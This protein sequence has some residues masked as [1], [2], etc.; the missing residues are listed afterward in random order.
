FSNGT[1]SP[2]LWHGT[3]ASWEALPFPEDF[4]DDN[5]G[6]AY[7]AE[8]ACWTV[9]TGGNYLYAGGFVTRWR[10]DADATNPCAVIWLS[11]LSACA[12]DFNHNGLVDFFDY[13]D[14]VQA[15]ANNDPAADFNHDGQIDFFDYLD[16]GQA[17]SAGC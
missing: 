10:E 5:G 9:W 3:A 15:F 13:L 4:S 11:P 17:F 2:G 12:G 6:W 1:T 14:F 8:S 7:W 16:F